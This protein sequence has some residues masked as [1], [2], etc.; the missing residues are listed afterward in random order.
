M[1]FEERGR[2]WWDLMRRGGVGGYFRRRVACKGCREVGLNWGVLGTGS[3]WSRGFEE[4]G[5]R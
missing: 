2:C 3:R 4:S 5:R 1:G